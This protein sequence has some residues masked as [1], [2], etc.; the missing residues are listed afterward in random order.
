MSTVFPEK[1]DFKTFIYGLIF[2]KGI[3]LVNVCVGKQDF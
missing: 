2:T 1:N 3:N